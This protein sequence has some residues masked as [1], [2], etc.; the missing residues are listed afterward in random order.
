[1]LHFIGMLMA[2]PNP[3]GSDIVAQMLPRS[4]RQRLMDR[5]LQDNYQ[6]AEQDANEESSISDSDL[7]LRIGNGDK[8]AESALYSRYRSGLVLM[9]NRQTR[10]MQRAEDLVQDTLLTVITRLRDQ[11]IDNPAALPRFI[12][13]TAKYTFIGW[14]RRA[15][16]QV[17]L[18][19]S[20]E[21]QTAD[22]TSVIDNISRDR[23]RSAVRSLIEEMKVP[24]DREILH[25][26]YVR[27]QS[28]PVICEALD[29]SMPHFDRVINRARNRFKQLVPEDWKNDV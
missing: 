15:G 18:R 24:R 14:L 13:Q 17:E 10:D 22:D 23:L 21:D 3:D 4:W 8:T 2:Q 28:K 16:N 7:A 5:A 20:F 9:L 27:E 1:M 29:L 19:D 25:R 6:D 12:Q 11:G 26:Y